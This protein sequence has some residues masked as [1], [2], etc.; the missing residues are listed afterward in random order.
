MGLSGLW[1]LSAG[2]VGSL[3]PAGAP[4]IS[5]LRLRAWAFS[6]KASASIL[7]VKQNA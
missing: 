7:G 3:V 5:S 4:G 6:V 1:G 2:R